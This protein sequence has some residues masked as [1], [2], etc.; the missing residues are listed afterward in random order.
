MGVARVLGERSRMSLSGAGEGL[1]MRDTGRR[2]SL[3]LF[4]IG[5]FF[6]AALGRPAVCPASVSSANAIN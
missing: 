4:R 6:A 1:F 5:R 2:L 3:I